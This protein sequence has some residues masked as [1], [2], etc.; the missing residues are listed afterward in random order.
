MPKIDVLDKG[1][2][3]SSPLTVYKAVLDEYSG[4]THWMPDSLTFK[5]RGG[6]PFDCV[7][8]ICDINGHSH[9]A[10]A[11]FSVELKKLVEGR[12]IE[13]EL[14]G[15]FLG[16]ETWTF[17]P[18][19]GGTRVQLHWVGRTNKLLLSLFSPFLNV[20]KMHSDATQKGF[21][22]CNSLLSKK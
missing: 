9:G 4:R 2:I 3:D 21:K 15:D 10:S 17:E 6:K 22:G 11:K 16:T 13:M 8:A 12:L 18:T 20:E 7:G 19:D 14:A 5:P 1:I